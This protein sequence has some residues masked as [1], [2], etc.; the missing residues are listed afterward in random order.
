M[1]DKI[2]VYSPVNISKV[3]GISPAEISKLSAGEKI[4]L[5]QLYYANKAN[6]NC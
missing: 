4:K 1:Q 5:L 3:T 2:I 6:N